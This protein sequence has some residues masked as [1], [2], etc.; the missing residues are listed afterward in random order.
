M[1]DDTGKPNLIWP[2]YGFI[3]CISLPILVL[4]V[5]ILRHTIQNEGFIAF[6]GLGIVAAS[7]SFIL[8]P[9]VAVQT[10]RE[11]D[12]IEKE[13]RRRTGPN[14]HPSEQGPS[15]GQLHVFSARA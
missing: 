14:H 2:L 11:L 9:I 8:L 1:S 12:E 4:D 10:Y 6:E 13:R 15:A 7:L 3:L 5:L